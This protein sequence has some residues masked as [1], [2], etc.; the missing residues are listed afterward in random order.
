MF[1]GLRNIFSPRDRLETSEMRQVAVD[2]HT[3]MMLHDVVN[4]IVEGLGFRAAM[5]AVVEDRIEDGQTIPVIAV[6]AFATQ[7]KFIPGGDQRL[8]DWGEALTGTK[9]IGNYIALNDE[10][11]EINAAVRAIRQNKSHIIVDSLYELFRPALDDEGLCNL[12][13]NTAGIKS[14][15]TVPFMNKE[16]ELLGNLYAGHN[17]AEIPPDMIRQLKAFTSMATTALDNA[18]LYRNNMRTTGREEILK[19]TITHLLTVT[20]DAQRLLDDIAA[21]VVD[22]MGFRACMVAIVEQHGDKKILRVVSYQFT[23]GL[24]GLLEWG[25]KLVNLRMEGQQLNLDEETAKINLAV[26]AVLEEMPHARTD[27][28]SDLF[29]PVLPSMISNQF[30]RQFGMKELI[31]VP[32]RNREGQL[33]GNMYAGSGGTI[34]DAEIDELK[35]FALAASI[36]IDNANQYHR[37]EHLYRE[38]RRMGLMASNFGH[39]AHKINN[40]LGFAQTTLDRELR[41]EETNLTEKQITR[42]A[43]V[44][45]EIANALQLIDEL[46]QRVNTEDEKS[47]NMNEAL[48]GAF[49]ALR[50]GSFG[51][52]LPAG[53]ETEINI[54]AEPMVVSATDELS[55]IFRVIMKNACEAMGES[56]KLQVTLQPRHDDSSGRDMALVK[57]T[58]NGPGIPVE[59]RKSLFELKTDSSKSGGLGYGIW[60]AY[61]TVQWYGGIIRYDTITQAEIDADPTLDGKTPGTTAIIELPLIPAVTDELAGTN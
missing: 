6:R 59:K 47:I 3:E 2:H 26:R 25:Q 15:V 33:R 4:A 54:P 16:G 17:A 42:F 39:A 19:K 58:D 14:F 34:T 27:K 10:N 48:K 21:A 5:V 18:Q 40:M 32:L 57:I 51:Y 61:L 22:I 36:A 53:I 45:Q 50:S 24:Q 11:E 37:T 41:R 13:Q 23:P 31:T 60:G 20:L 28:L 55:E 43:D 8:L 9:L 38:S 1:R 29:A 46:K 7:V 30:Q 44:R 49:E 56:G 12:L 35:T 52:Q